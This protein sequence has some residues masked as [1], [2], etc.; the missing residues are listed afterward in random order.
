MRSL[1]SF[2]TEATLTLRG[3]PVAGSRTSTRFAWPENSVLIAAFSSADIVSFSPAF[4]GR[5]AAS[6][7]SALAI[8]LSAF[9]TRLFILATSRFVYVMPGSPIPASS[10]LAAFRSLTP[11]SRSL[12]ASASLADPIA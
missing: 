5:A 11:S 8:F 9:F 1:A 6:C 12:I 7:L 3:L 10:V 4:A 2:G